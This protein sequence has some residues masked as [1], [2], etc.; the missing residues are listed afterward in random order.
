MFL[1]TT[2][3]TRRQDDSKLFGFTEIN[4]LRVDVRA[5]QAQSFFSPIFLILLNNSEQK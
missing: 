3:T 2:F 4:S 1:Y 5:E